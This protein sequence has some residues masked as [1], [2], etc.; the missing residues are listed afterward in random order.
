MTPVADL[1]MNQI[2]HAAV[3]RDLARM[4]TALRAFPDRDGA[5]AADLRRAWGALWSQLRRHHEL[6]DEHVWPYVRTLGVVDP[7]VVDAMEAEHHAM[8]AA[9]EV[10]T[11]GIDAVAA[12]PT[13]AHAVAAADAVA[14]AARVTDS[15]LEHEERAITPVIQERMETPEW[16]AIEKEFRKGSLVQGGQFIAWL[17]DGGEPEVLAALRSTIPPPVLFLLSRGFGR[18]YHR[19]VAPVWR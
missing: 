2:I 3:R 19:S 8:A 11:A 12:D 5:R 16:K 15:H 18:S 14:E 4:E 6:E 9:C 13:T 7:A 1:D 10:A 17:Q